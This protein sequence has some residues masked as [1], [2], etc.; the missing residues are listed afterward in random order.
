MSIT[1]LTS[2]P[3]HR[4]TKLTLCTEVYIKGLWSSAGASR[5]LWGG[6]VSGTESSFGPKGKPRRGKEGGERRVEGGM[7][8]SWKPLSGER[9]ARRPPGISELRSGG[10]AENSGGGRSRR[11]SIPGLGSQS[12]GQREIATKP[13]PG[14]ASRRGRKGGARNGKD[15][16][17][18]VPSD[19]LE[20]GSL[21]RA[22]G[23]LQGGPSGWAR[24]KG[25]PRWGPKRSP[26]DRVQ[27]ESPGPPR[28]RPGGVP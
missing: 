22:R 7:V 3:E 9:G 1:V 27:G 12:R 15:R 10:G 25:S 20:P 13:F 6:A 28:W 2:V 23:S 14:R 24:A 19:P 26:L 16:G 17:E 21:D 8:R 11:E 18:K 5:P 4:C